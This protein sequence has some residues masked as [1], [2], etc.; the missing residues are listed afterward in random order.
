MPV[1]R[2]SRPTDAGLCPRQVLSEDPELGRDPG[3][4]LSKTWR[5]ALVSPSTWGRRCPGP[6]AAVCVHCTSVLSTYYVLMAKPRA[7]NG[8]PGRTAFPRGAVQR[9]RGVEGRGFRFQLR[10]VEGGQGTARPP[11]GMGSSVLGS[12]ARTCSGRGVQPQGVTDEADGSVGLTLGGWKFLARPGLVSGGLHC[13]P[14]DSQPRARPPQPPAS[15]WATGT[16]PDS[17]SHRPQTD[18]AFR[19][20]TAHRPGQGRGDT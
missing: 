8:E 12:S 18:C 5:D 14:K 10:S 1:F 15:V 20:K 7:G 19:V 2:R 13:R 16:S 17:P 11:P 9:L 3:R 4:T 6:C